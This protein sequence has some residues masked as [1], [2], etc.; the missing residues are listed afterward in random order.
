MN[1][2]NR[3]MLQN[4]DDV[5][6][7]IAQKIDITE[8]L[9]EKARTRYQSVGEW[10]D[11][12]DSTIRRYSPE[13]YPQGSFLLGT[14]IRPVGDADAFDIDLVCKL[15]ADKRHFT[16]ASLKNIVGN[17]LFEYSKYHRMQKYPKDGHRCW[18]LE[19]SDNAKFHMDI[20][21]ALPNEKDYQDLL[22]FSGY[23]NLANDR[24]IVQEAIAI[25]DKKNPKFF[26]YTDDWPIS[27][28]KG[29]AVWFKSRQ[30]EVI[31][32]LKRSIM[33]REI[34]YFSIEEIP[35]HKV[36][37]PLQR[38]IQLL[39]RHRDTMFI[40]R[41][42]KPISIIITT[43]AAHAYNG[44]VTISEALRTILKL[45]GC[46]IENRN[47]TYWIQNPVNPNENFA[48]KWAENITKA[49]DFFDWLKRAQ[50]D[51]GT[52]LTDD[53]TV[54]NHALKESMTEI[55]LAKA[56]PS[57]ALFA[58]TGLSSSNA[59]LEEA[60]RIMNQGGQTRPWLQ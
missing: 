40:G 53:F 9:E 20:L 46:Y 12:E 17:E 28:P 27:N 54:I 7:S 10:L 50:R 36:K 58:P 49:S 29:Y 3:K 51:F 11:R 13:V 55:T 48:D 23:R 38:A 19:Y 59:G 35:D 6:E 1:T 18:T 32:N 57:I 2:T 30:A 60:K 24:E 8:S 44:E 42:D 39:K 15:R 4:H 14:V 37:T 45:M 34:I 21:P 25:T 56:I 5:L 16:M 22:E 33:E 26:N 52:Y 41:S 31:N 43:L 47:G